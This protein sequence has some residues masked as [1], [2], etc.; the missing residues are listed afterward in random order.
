[1]RS[2]MRPVTLSRVF[3]TVW[4]AKENSPVSISALSLYLQSSQERAK[5]I[6]E[7]VV[8]MKLLTKDVHGYTLTDKGD[9]F[10][11]AVLN[12]DWKEIHSLLGDYSFYREFYDIIKKCGP[13]P[14]EKILDALKMSPVHFNTAS[15][16]VLCDWGER[17]EVIQRNVFS[18][19]F[20]AV[21]P[22][23]EDFKSC[24]LDAYRELN[25]H[26]NPFMEKHYIEIPNIR[27]YMCEKWTFSRHEFDQEFLKL[28]I[29]NIGKIELTGAP[30]TTH[31]KFSSKK[32]KTTNISQIP[33]RFQIVL[34]SDQFL[35][36]ITINGKTYYSVA[37]HGGDLSV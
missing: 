32:I 17:L 18:G 15:V 13:L 33:D 21:S 29:K 22:F 16:H 1:M 26:L 8:N 30:I 4:Y 5:E 12:K 37:Y 14:Q 23:S 34:S 28:Y 27:E 20:Y 10:V 24:F 36:G 11:N 6:A 25:I 7:E 3:E 2:S 19:N 31:T 35:K 9:L